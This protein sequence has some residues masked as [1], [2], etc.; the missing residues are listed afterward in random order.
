M[1]TAPGK[2]C[3]I[4]HIASILLP[5]CILQTKLFRKKVKCGV[6]CSRRY[7]PLS[8]L[9]R[10]VIGGPNRTY[11]SVIGGPYRTYRFV[12]GGPI[13]HNVPL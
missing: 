2:Q 9:I 4:G 6:G 8:S 3:F 10:S 5:H 7:H 1:L 13:E 12:I 11:C